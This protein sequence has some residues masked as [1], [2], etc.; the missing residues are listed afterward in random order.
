MRADSVSLDDRRVVVELPQPRS[1]SQDAL[2]PRS[3]EGSG[4]CR[5]FSF[6]CDGLHLQPVQTVRAEV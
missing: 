2:V 3:L 1:V 6:S 4:C 5:T